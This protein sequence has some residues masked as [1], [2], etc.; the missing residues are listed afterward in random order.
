MSRLSLKNEMPI[1]EMAI[2]Q[3]G[4]VQAMLE[5]L[6]VHPED[7]EVQRQAIAVLLNVGCLNP[8]LQQQIKAVGGEAAIKAAM[9]APNA[10]ADTRKWG[11]QLLTTCQ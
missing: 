8:E 7:A 6:A 2:A 11:W 3:L 1:N 5:A 9:Q 10:S 4:G